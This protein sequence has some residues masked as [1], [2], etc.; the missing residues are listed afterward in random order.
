MKDFLI[1]ALPW[2]LIGLFLAILFANREKLKKENEIS[3]SICIWM[4]LGVTFGIVLKQLAIGISGG[5]LIGI[6]L[7]I[8]EKTKQ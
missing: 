7:G 3:S 4:C 2:I 6:L 5:L 1:A 8:S